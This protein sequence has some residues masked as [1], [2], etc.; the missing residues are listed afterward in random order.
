MTL[1]VFGTKAICHCDIVVGV[2]NTCRIVLPGMLL[3][4]KSTF[5][6]IGIAPIACAHTIVGD[7]TAI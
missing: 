5:L 4:D 3:I 6:Y 1:L 2:G 7:T